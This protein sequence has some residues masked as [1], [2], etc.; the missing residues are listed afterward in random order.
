M[1][2]GRRIGEQ[3][4]FPTQGK[5]VNGILAAVVVDRQIA[6]LGIADQTAPVFMQVGQ[7]RAQSDFRRDPWQRVLQPG[8]GV[9]SIGTLCC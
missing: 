7:Y 3:P 2:S 5:R 1:G 4:C 9:A 8:V 6:T